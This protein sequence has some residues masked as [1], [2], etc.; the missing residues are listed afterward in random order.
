[1]AALVCKAARSDFV[2]RP[3]PTRNLGEY[4]SEVR[5]LAFGELMQG[6]QISF[7]YNV[8][9]ELDLSDQIVM[10]LSEADATYLDRV[11]VAGMLVVQKNPL[12]MQRHYT[13]SPTD[14]R[15]S[16]FGASRDAQQNTPMFWIN[17][18]TADRILQSTGQSVEDLRR[19]AADLEQDEIFELETGVT[20]DMEIQGSVEERVVTYHVIGYIP[21]ESRVAGGAT[22]EGKLDDKMIVVMAQYD[23]PPLGPDGVDYLAANENASGVAV[24]LEMI[25]AMREAGYQPYKTF[26]FVAYS[27]EGIEGGARFI[28][29][30]AK[31]LQTK[32]GFSSNYQLEA[33]IELRGMGTQI[34]D[35]LILYTGGSLRLADLFE[36]AA[37]RMDV[38]VRRAGGDV[39]LSIVFEE[40][41]AYAGGE[42][43]PTIGLAW[44][45]WEITANT[46]ADTPDAVSQDHLELSGEALNL[47][48]MI[49]GRET[50]Y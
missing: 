12:D 10:V 38:P 34:G 47:A 21:G 46:S 11:P 23:S 8:L 20:V 14:P 22:G 44:E 30:V 29:E 35:E 25:R 36:A 43:A 1:M 48:M 19:L 13:L 15:W 18:T 40:R 42:E 5:F 16:I 7:Q 26:L 50:D 45:G 6:G 24:M 32:Y 41:S 49:L 17:E 39:D 33:I 28:P 3:S 4:R 27:G 31:F 9:Q 37:N 2:E